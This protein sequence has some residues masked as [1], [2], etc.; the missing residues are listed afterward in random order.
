LAACINLIKQ[1]IYIKTPMKIEKIIL[2]LLLFL[3][4]P[5][6]GLVYAQSCYQDGQKIN[7]TGSASPVKIENA[8]GNKEM[9]FIFNLGKMICVE[10]RTSNGIGIEKII[11]DK[12]QIIGD[13]PPA[14]EITL[15]GIIG[16]T[17]STGLNGEAIVFNTNL[18]AL[19]VQPK[20]E[21]GSQYDV[22]QSEPVIF[23]SNKD[24][25]KSILYMVGLFLA[26]AF[27]AILLGVT[28]HWVLPL[29]SFF[30]MMWVGFESLA[31]LL[32]VGCLFLALFFLYKKI[33]SSRA[34]K[35]YE[36]AIVAGIDLAIGI[37]ELHKDELV[38]RRKQ[39]TY[40]LAYGLEDSKKWENEKQLFITDV[41]FPK[42]P[43]LGE[44][45]AARYDLNQA[46][47]DITS[48]YR[49]SKVG[50]SDDMDPY[51]YERYVCDQLNGYEWSA[52]VTK[53][54]GDQGV[55]VLAEKNG[56]K[57][58]IQCK[59]Y[60]SPVGNDSVQQ[61][62]A[63][64]VFYNAQFAVVIS[65]SEFTRSAKQIAEVS[66]VILLHHDQLVNLD[67]LIFGN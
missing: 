34:E 59:L 8:V 24:N 19:P 48:S 41:I 23:D 62:L 53:A 33:R 25:P 2:I 66:K 43:G 57:I 26:L 4:A 38:A 32:L 36:A 29:I 40:K 61:V 67:N 12:V 55:D 37:I 15:S 30:A 28:R 27:S 46:L 49:E 20:S 21:A 42:M 7:L 51:D 31:I 58:A 13:A 16:A 56:I 64:K 60:N 35:A 65:N 18:Q 6:M 22:V 45:I 54:S 63:G 44:E 17:N 5:L 3:S 1:G 11:T 9:V 14:G 47:D 39:T 10:G 50:Y 52:W